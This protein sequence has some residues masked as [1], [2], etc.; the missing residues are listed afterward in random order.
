MVPIYEGSDSETDSTIPIYHMHSLNDYLSLWTGDAEDFIFKT[1][2]RMQLW[3]NLEYLLFE[4]NI[5]NEE[6][7]VARHKLI[8]SFVLSLNVKPHFS[9]EKLFWYCLYLRW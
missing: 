7:K 1:Q 8:Q 4:I 6:N 5:V 2:E 3:P 9:V